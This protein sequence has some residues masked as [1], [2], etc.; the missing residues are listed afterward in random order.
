MKWFFKCFTKI[1]TR[2]KRCLSS[3]QQRQIGDINAS[4]GKNCLHGLVTYRVN[5]KSFVLVLFHIK[6]DIALIDS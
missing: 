5:I 2:E 3:W 6:Q 4:C 1:V